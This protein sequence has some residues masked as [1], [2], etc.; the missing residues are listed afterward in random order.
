MAKQ[1]ILAMK[2]H[3]LPCNIVMRAI[4]IKELKAAGPFKFTVKIWAKPA[5]PLHGFV[6]IALMAVEILLAR[7]DYS[8]A[9]EIGMARQKN[10]KKA[11]HAH[12][13]GT[14]NYTEN[15][16]VLKNVYAVGAEIAVAHWLG[17]KDFVPHVDTFK[18]E[19]D[20]FPDWEVKHT[21]NMERNYGF[22]QTNDNDRDR[23]VFVRGWPIF[24]II[25]WLPVSYCKHPDWLGPWNGRPNAYK[26]PYAELVRAR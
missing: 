1:F 16:I 6:G 3:N 17:V 7:E 18:N 22:V 20:V 14:F 23:V 24:Q 4:V 25:G 5:K 26:V 11:G 15:E 8:L 9:I 2:P 13:Y 21:M 12:R 19:P 10:S